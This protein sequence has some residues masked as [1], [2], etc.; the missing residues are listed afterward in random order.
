MDVRVQ[1]EVSALLRDIDRK[2][3]GLDAVL[4]R[5]MEET[6]QRV[7]SESQELVPVDT[8]AL[9][10]SGRIIK[11][12]GITAGGLPEVLVVYGNGN[13]D[14]AVTVHED[15]S[16]HHDSPTQAKFL[17]IPLIRNESFLVSRLRQQLQV[18]LTS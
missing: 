5:V 7:Y 11:T 12:G 1:V 14:Y 18:L 4:M 10:D 13:V 17:E 8:G 3:A 16:V 6:M 15:L 2:K 9:R